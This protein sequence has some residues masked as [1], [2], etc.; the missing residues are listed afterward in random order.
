MLKPVGT[1]CWRFASCSV[2]GLCV[3]C[4]FHS[5]ALRWARVALITSLAMVDHCL[6][7]AILFWDS[8]PICHTHM[9]LASS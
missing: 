5:T 4:C 6:H 8:A 7:F 1:L 9:P 2:V 3:N